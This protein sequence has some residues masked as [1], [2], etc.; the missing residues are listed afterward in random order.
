MT[1]IMHKLTIRLYDYNYKYDYVQLIST[2]MRA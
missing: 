1:D 2:D